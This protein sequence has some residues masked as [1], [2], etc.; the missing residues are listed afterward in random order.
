METPK[1]V[2]S[3]LLSK[4]LSLIDLS[5][6]S[7]PNKTWFLLLKDLPPERKFLSLLLLPP[8]SPELATKLEWEEFPDLASTWS[9][10]TL[11]FPLEKMDLLK[12]H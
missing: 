10:L 3:P 7:S 1:T 2:L 12:W 6:V 5:N 8:S 9:D 11:E 4:K